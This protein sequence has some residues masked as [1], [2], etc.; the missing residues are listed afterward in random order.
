MCLISLAI[1]Q[2]FFDDLF[3]FE[4]VDTLKVSMT[5]KVLVFFLNFCLMEVKVIKFRYITKLCYFWAV[6]IPE[7]IPKIETPEQLLKQQIKNR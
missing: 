5:S 6:D 2:L 3:E 7:N 4:I 1:N